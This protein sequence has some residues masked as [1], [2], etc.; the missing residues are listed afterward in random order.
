M[1][2]TELNR[3]NDLFEKMLSSEANKIEKRELTHLYQEY[4]DDGREYVCRTQH[5]AD[6][7][8]VLIN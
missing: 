8:Q 1:K 6:M 4:I 3:L 7:K 2:Q 5:R